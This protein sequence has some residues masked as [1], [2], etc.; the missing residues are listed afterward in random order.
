MLGFTLTPLHFL[1]F[2][3]FAKTCLTIEPT[4]DGL[5]PQNQMALRA[6]TI[7]KIDCLT[8]TSDQI[9]VDSPFEFKSIV[10]SPLYGFAIWF[11]TYFD[12]ASPPIILTTSPEWF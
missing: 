7:K 4:V 2:R 12:V 8:V 3:N 9:F 1:I 11:N 5:D 6:C 10:S